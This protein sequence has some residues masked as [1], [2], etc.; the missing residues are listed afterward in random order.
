LTLAADASGSPNLISFARRLAS[1]LERGEPLAGT[2]KHSGLPP[3]LRWFLSA[4]E[5]QG[6]LAASLRGAAGDYRQRALERADWIG[7]FVPLMMTVGLGGTVALAYALSI[8]APWIMT[9][10]E[11]AQP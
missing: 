3:L 1:D 7:I 4:G 10:E 11:M 8:F 5:R 6:N 9:L 2:L